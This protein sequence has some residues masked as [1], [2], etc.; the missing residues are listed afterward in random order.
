MKIAIIDDEAHQRLKIKTDLIKEFTERKITAELT[1]FESG[2][3]FMEAF[4]PGTFYAVFLDVYMRG[5]SGIEVGEALYQNDPD[6]KIIFLTGSEDYIRESYSV[7]AIYYLVK[8]YELRQLQQALDFAFPKPKTEDI[9]TIR[10]KDGMTVIPRADIL[11]IE[12][13][14][15][16]S[17]IHVSGR[18]IECLDSFAEVSNPLETDKRFFVCCRGV[19]VNLGKI[20]TQKE[21]DFIMTDGQSVPISRRVK[22]EAVKAFQAYISN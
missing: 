2:E 18:D 20:V 17:N 21:N 8:P 11:Y 6:C 12:A 22:S 3:A 15:R 14:G 19:M 4:V 1:E 7:R 10:D 5:M 9:L 16:Y 13:Q